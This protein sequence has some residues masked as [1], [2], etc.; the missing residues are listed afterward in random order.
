VTLKSTVV[1]IL[2]NDIDIQSFNVS[3]HVSGKACTV[4]FTSIIT[5]DSNV[6]PKSIR[7]R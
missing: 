3:I 7:V 4:D 5:G 2:P 6:P 1:V